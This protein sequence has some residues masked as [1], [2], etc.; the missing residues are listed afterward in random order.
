MGREDGVSARRDPAGH[1]GFPEGLV[2][3]EIEDAAL[4]LG[5]P[6]RSGAQGDRDPTD[7]EEQEEGSQQADEDATGRA[8]RT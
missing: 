5:R 1:E 8:T 7:R 4:H 6:E 3:R 2:L